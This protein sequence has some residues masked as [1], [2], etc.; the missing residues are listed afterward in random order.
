MSDNKKWFKTWT[1]ILTDHAHA[2]MT[3][4]M[5][6]RWTRLMAHVASSGERG[7]LKINAQAKRFFFDLETTWEEVR[8]VLKALPNVQISD[9]NND[10]GEF[11]VTLKNWHKY[12]V[13]STVGE[14]VRRLRSKKR[15]EEKLTSKSTS[16]S[17]RPATL[18]ATRALTAVAVNESMDKPVKAYEEA[19][20]NELCGP[21]TGMWEK[22][23]KG[24]P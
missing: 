1:S 21:P 7:K 13:D 19:D 2:N 11:I 9:L 23:K 17:A 8:N 22:V 18:S 20:E 6:G 14:R 10:Y 16:S 15:G 12:Q 24:I 5:V 4:E 3:C